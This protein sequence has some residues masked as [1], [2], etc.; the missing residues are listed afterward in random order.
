VSAF[1]FDVGRIRERVLAQDGGLRIAVLPVKNDS[2]DPSQ[3]KF[4]DNMTDEL[5]AA[6]QEIKSVSA[7][8]RATV[9]QYKGAKKTVPQIARELN[10][11]RVVDAS[12]IRSGDRVSVT[13][14]LSMRSRTGI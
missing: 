1:A 13:A 9:M 10:V 7:I 11:K 2:D 5:I 8:S 12:V 3:E 6:Q 4:A 14:R